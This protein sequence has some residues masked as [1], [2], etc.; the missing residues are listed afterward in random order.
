MTASVAYGWAGAVMLFEPLFGVI[1]QSVTDGPTDQPTELRVQSYVR[2]NNSIRLFRI[3]DPLC[4]DYQIEN[5]SVSHLFDCPA[6]P[7][8]LTPSDLWTQP[9]EVARFLNSIPAFSHLPTIGPPPQ[10]RQR[11]RPP[12]EPPP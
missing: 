8:Q 6:H 3:G 7:T 12:P 4:P 2:Q 11:R 5:A 1:L 9:Y 10:R